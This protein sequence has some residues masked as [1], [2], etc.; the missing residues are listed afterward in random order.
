[1]THGTIP[2]IGG[3]GNPIHFRVDN[4]EDWV[5]LTDIGSTL[6]KAELRLEQL[7]IENGRLKDEKEM[8]ERRAKGVSSFVLESKEDLQKRVLFLEMMFKKLLSAHLNLFSINWQLAAEGDLCKPLNL[9]EVSND[10]IEKANI[11]LRE[12]EKVQKRF[13]YRDKG[14]F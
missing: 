13:Y 6:N 10:W 8:A 1:M 12:G 11:L 14:S 5:R 2:P 3:K 9:D 7:K 4:P